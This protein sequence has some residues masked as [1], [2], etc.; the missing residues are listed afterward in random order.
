MTSASPVKGLHRLLY[1]LTLDTLTVYKYLHSYEDMAENG[2]AHF[3]LMVFI[4]HFLGWCDMWTK[5]HFHVERTWP[6]GN[7]KRRAG[8]ILM[9]G[10]L[11][12]FVAMNRMET[13]FLIPVDSLLT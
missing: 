7:E 11:D 2:T 1:D 13:V 12:I 3:M 6:G 9:K 10:T 5:F 4:F 8:D